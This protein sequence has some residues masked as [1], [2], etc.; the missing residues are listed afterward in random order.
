MVVTAGIA[1]EFCL[2]LWTAD[3]MREQVG[4]AAGPAAASVTAVVGGMAVGRLGGGR[5]ALRYPLDGL[6]YG[7]IALTA[8]GFT[9]FWLTTSVWLALPAL[10]ACGVGIALFYPLGVARAIN[11]SEGRPD[12]ASARA[13]IGAALASGVG[14]FVL[15]ALADQVGLH[16]AL[17]VVPAL[18]VVAAVGLRLGRLPATSAASPS[19]AGAS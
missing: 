13:G 10:L 3:V 14:P 2:V 8:L 16:R 1:V 6:L 5:L 11:A 19:A 15:G 9:V 18:L 7:A 4:L 12:H 17:L